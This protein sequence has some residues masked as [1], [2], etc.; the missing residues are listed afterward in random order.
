MLQE[1]KLE[2]YFFLLGVQQPPALKVDISK[3]PEAGEADENR[4]HKIGA[5]MK[6]WPPSHADKLSRMIRDF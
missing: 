3:A 5:T 1:G 2:I 6:S 4:I